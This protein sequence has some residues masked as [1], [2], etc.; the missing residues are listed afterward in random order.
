M[1]KTNPLNTLLCLLAL[2]LVIVPGLIPHAIA[3]AVNCEPDPGTDMDIEY[4]DTVLCEFET[5]DDSDIFHFVGNKGDNPFIRLMRGTGATV[6]DYVSLFLY[7]PGGVLLA[8]DPAADGLRTRTAEINDFVL[9]ED[10]VHTIVARAELLGTGDVGLDYTLELPCLAGKCAN[11][12]LP[13]SLGYTAV[14]PCRIVDTRYG[15]GG[16]MSP[17]ETRHYNTYGDISAQNKL[18]GGAPAGYPDECPF[19]LGEHAAV[20]LNVTVVP[21]GPSG[22]RGFLTIW[23]HGGAQPSSSFIN[24]KAGT[25]NVA[26]AGTVKTHSS[27]GATA[28]ISVYAL[29]HIDLVI[30]VMGYY[31]E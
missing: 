19:P 11:A 1:P 20:H 24:Y 22:E 14:P 4:S 23:P 16:S 29:R 25:Q 15:T 9:T 21:R 18:G 27:D 26:N 3:E 7:S 31:T 30:D 5:D 2:V 17:G 10:G 28:D 12:P 13:A 8:R 6:S